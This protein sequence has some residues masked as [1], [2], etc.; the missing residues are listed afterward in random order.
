MNFVPWKMIQTQ[1]PWTTLRWLPSKFIAHQVD[2]KQLIQSSDVA[3][4]GLRPRGVF[5]LILLNNYNGG[6]VNRLDDG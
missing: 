5:H 4:S 2:A 6:P 3:R 1:C